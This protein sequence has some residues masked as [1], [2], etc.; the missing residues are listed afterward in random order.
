MTE[1]LAH[2]DGFF[3]FFVYVHILPSNFEVRKMSWKK[4]KRKTMKVISWHLTQE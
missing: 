1:N 2:S 4:K 3:P